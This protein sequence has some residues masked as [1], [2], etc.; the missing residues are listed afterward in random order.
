MIKIHELKTDPNHFQDV[1][2]ERK[3]F[4]YRWNGD[5]DFKEGDVLILKETRYSS[6]QMIYSD[7]PLEYTGRVIHTHI[8]HILCGEKYDIMYGYSVLSLAKERTKF[9]GVQKS[10]G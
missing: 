1:W 8:S 5:R 2:D 6:D 3:T 9:V 10:K 7:K 4:E